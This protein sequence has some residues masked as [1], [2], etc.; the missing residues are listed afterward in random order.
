[1]ELERVR[2]REEALIR[3]SLRAARKMPSNLGKKKAWRGSGGRRKRA[4]YAL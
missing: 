1:M 2:P 3:F 4:H